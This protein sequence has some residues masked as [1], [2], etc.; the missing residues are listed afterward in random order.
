MEKLSVKKI[1]AARELLGWSQELLAAASGVSLPTVQRLEAAGGDLGGKP[2]T[3][4]KII[5]AFTGAGI[6]FTHD[7]MRLR[8]R[9]G[10]L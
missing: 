8:V 2:E 4:G 10:P 9:K 7:G 5:A 1:K 6:E 3:R